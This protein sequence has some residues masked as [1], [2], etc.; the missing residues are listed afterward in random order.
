MEKGAQRYGQWGIRLARPIAPGSRGGHPG[1]ARKSGWAGLRSNSP[2]R[3]TLNMV[4]EEGMDV[5]GTWQMVDIV[6]PLSSVRQSCKQR[7]RVIFG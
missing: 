3:K 5:L 7:N 1:A 2:W 4:T 6:R